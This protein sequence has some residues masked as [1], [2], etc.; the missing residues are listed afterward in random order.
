MASK[1]VSPLFH[2]DKLRYPVLLFHGEDDPRVPIQQTNTLMQK[3]QEKRGN[4]CVDGSEFIRFA[5]EGHGIRKESNALYMYHRVEKF[6]CRHLELPDPPDLE[7]LWIDGHTG[8]DISA[9][10]IHY[11]NSTQLHKDD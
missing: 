11:A 10:T 3:L 5:N 4:V 8:T 2:I 1:R 7:E 6:L 9:S